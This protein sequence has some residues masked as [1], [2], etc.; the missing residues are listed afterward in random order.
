VDEAGSGVVVAGVGAEEAFVAAGELLIAVGAQRLDVFLARAAGAF[1]LEPSRQAA[2][3]G[4]A[5]RQ[6]AG[7]DLE[8]GQG[9][10]ERVVQQPNPDGGTSAKGVNGAL[11]S[12][13]V[14][15]AP[16]RR[17]SR[18]VQYSEP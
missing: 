12:G 17:G 16:T 14:I 15:W 1:V 3:A 2:V 10:A 5:L 8:A 4:E 9:G 7:P 13:S 18:W 11:V 6:H